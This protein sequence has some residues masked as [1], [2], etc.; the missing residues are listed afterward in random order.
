MAAAFAL[1]IDISVAQARISGPIF[2]LQQ[3][4][5]FAYR[6]QITRGQLEYTG[7]QLFEFLLWKRAT[8]SDFLAWRDPVLQDIDLT[9]ELKR[10]LGCKEPNQAIK[11]FSPALLPI[12]ASQ[13]VLI[14]LNFGVKW[15]CGTQVGNT[16]ARAVLGTRL[17]NNILTFDPSSL[18]ISIEE[19]P[20][21]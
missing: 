5:R 14:T 15:R 13:T 4:V 16:S 10:E 20:N 11:I 21:L 6:R 8:D 17:I 18:F 19:R 7:G 1:W 2:N 3:K 9:K 12:Q